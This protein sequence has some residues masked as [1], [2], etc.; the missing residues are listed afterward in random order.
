MDQLFSIVF[1]FLRF[2]IF[3]F[4]VDYSSEYIK[5]VKT[6]IGFLLHK[7]MLC[8]FLLFIN[9]CSNRCF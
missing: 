2:I 4:S 8:L 1:V 5:V 6:Q 3:F 7:K 9:T